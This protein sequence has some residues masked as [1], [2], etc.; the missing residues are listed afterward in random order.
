MVDVTFADSFNTNT[1]VY[2][3]ANAYWLGSAAR[4]S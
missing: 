1:R 2:S 4:L 3:R